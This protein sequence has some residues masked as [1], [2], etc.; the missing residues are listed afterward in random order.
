MLVDGGPN[1]EPRRLLTGIRHKDGDKQRRDVD[2]QNRAEDVLTGR[3][4]NLSWSAIGRLVLPH[5]QRNSNTLHIVAPQ[6]QRNGDG[7]ANLFRDELLTSIRGSKI[8]LGTSSRNFR[9]ID[10]IVGYG[11]STVTDNSGRS[12]CGISIPTKGRCGSL[13]AR[14]ACSIGIPTK[15]RCG[16]L[17]ANCGIGTPP[18]EGAEA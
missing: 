8:Q 12:N 2:I 11:V 3:A 7:L 16:S 9:I 1:I 10:R 13:T 4:V 6:K 5:P 17:A 15:G 18:K 14:D